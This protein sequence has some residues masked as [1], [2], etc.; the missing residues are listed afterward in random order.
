MQK[1]LIILGSTSTGKTSLAI[2]LAKSFNGELIAC[3]S[4]QIYKGLD[5]G[6]GKLPDEE[7]VTKKYRGFW[8][9]DGINVWMY[10][11]TNFEGQYT[12]YNYIKDA[13]SAI[14]NIINRKKL[15]IIL[16]GSGLYLKLLLEGL[17]DLSVCANPKLRKELENLS[18]TDLQ[19][20]L[21]HVAMD[22][23]ERMNNSDRQN[24]RRLIRAIEF[25]LSKD[26]TGIKFKGLN[27]IYSLFKIGLTAPRE[28]LY[29]R[30]DKRVIS[31]INQGMIQEAERLNKKTLSFSRM[32]QLGLEYGVLADYLEGRI[33]D[34]NELIK[35]L[36]GKIHGFARRQLTWFKKEKD[37]IWFDITGKRWKDKV[38]NKVRSWYYLKNDQAY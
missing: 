22:R 21:Q 23:W 30:I 29:K 25:K 19:L 28:I 2:D 31:R 7:V 6:T 1:V 32:R 17:S 18:L 34:R 27:K 8:E 20:R 16:G 13:N 36:Q 3:D 26:N 38:E 4:R 24:S 33:A 10:D 5:I 37:V 14:E 12:V 15:P 35:I 11:E 9:M